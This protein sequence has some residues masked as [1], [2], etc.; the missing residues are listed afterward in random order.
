MEYLTN[1]VIRYAHTL[2]VLKSTA[3]PIVRCHLADP[4]N[5]SFKTSMQNPIET[6]A[7]VN[8][9]F[10]QLGIDV[11]FAYFVGRAGENR[12]HAHWAHQ[13]VIRLEQAILVE[14]RT[15]QFIADALF[16]PAGTE[17][18]LVAPH[19]LSLFFDPTTP[20]SHAIQ[21][22]IGQVHGA[23]Q[24]QRLPEDLADFFK[25]AMT[26][27]R[28]TPALHHYLSAHLV[29]QIPAPG[30]DP[31]L[32]LILRRIKEELQTKNSS[33]HELSSEIALSSSRFSHWFREQT[34]MPLRSY[35]KW[36]RLVLALESILDGTA[37]L[38]AAHLAGFS[39]QAHFS[40]TF[41][42][43]FGAPPI[44]L[45]RQLKRRP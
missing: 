12:P 15:D 27:A 34:G 20:L 37:P 26:E 9:W 10:G 33:R 40:R 39:D 5:S 44:E 19:H 7:P 32:D 38:E 11:G 21:K 17:H 28:S 8:A 3:A 23:S 1:G 30:G 29:N 42:A 36:L 41:V 18:R 43:M 2:R 24:P 45:M 16:I 25:S 22:K 4:K 14:S 13:C 31:R 35:R 6:P